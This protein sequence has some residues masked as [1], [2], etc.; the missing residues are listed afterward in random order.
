MKLTEHH[1]FTVRD[2]GVQDIDVYDVEVEDNH[3]FFANDIL[4][5]NSVY[6][7]LTTLVERVWPN[8]D[9]SEVV[10]LLDQACQTKIENTLDQGYEQLAQL[11]HAARQTMK[12]E[13]EAIGEGVFVSKKRYVINLFD[14]EGVRFSKPKLKVMGLEAT[15]SD[16]PEWGRERMKAIYE[17]MF[18]ESE[19]TIHQMVREYWEEM[20][21]APLDLIAQTT[22]VQNLAKYRTSTGFASGTPK[23]VKGAL[24]FNQL[25]QK[26]GLKETYPQIADGEKVKML[27]LR[28]PN[29]IMTNAICYSDH[30]P[31]EFG[32]EPYIDYKSHFNA[33]LKEPIE[34][35]LNTFDWS[36]EKKIDLLDELFS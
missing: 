2:A 26:H 6:L 7:D 3:N 27:P 36:A 28:L 21:S 23:H 35:V 18:T 33:V 1:E 34:R 5:H 19:E 30:L 22:S 12:M 20:T 13:R 4:V 24:M 9:E 25:L 31:Q 8:K 10:D 11:V 16:I 14:N 17:A 29:P 15:R 32:L